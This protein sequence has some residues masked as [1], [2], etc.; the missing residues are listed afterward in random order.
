MFGSQTRFMQ[1][2]AP[3]ALSIELQSLTAEPNM[4]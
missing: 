3:M 2:R 4:K 1:W